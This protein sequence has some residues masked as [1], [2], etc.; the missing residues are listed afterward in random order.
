MMPSTFARL[1][2]GE[3]FG[4]QRNAD[5]G[6]GPGADTGKKAEHSE[7]QGGLGQALARR[8]K[9]E[10]QDAE[11]QGADAADIIGDDAEQE[12]ADGPSQQPGHGE[13]ATDRADLRRV[14]MAA[15]QLGHCRTQRKGEEAEIRRI[16][17]PSP[18]R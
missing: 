6:F 2:C 10:H 18:A 1:L 17:A 4:H 12:A 13:I 9:A 7:L 14:R 11:P 15:Q 5:H 8:E 3:N 16:R